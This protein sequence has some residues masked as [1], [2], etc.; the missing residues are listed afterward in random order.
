MS[1]THTALGLTVA[2]MLA[3]TACGRAED[4]PPAGAPPAV[5]VDRSD[6]RSNSVDSAY[7]VPCGRL[8]QSRC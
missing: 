4:R 8:P 1:R 5:T 7:G 2:A 3:L 6:S